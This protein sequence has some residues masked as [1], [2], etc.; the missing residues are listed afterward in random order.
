[1]VCLSHALA[2]K[3]SVIL[4]EKILLDQLAQGDRDAFWQ[5]WELHRDYLYHRCRFW[6]GGNYSEGEEALSLA[7]LKAWE[8]LP[9]YAAQITNVKAWLTRMTHNLCV[10]L[11][12][13]R[14]RTAIGVDKIEEITS[15]E[16]ES[17]ASNNY[18]PEANLLRRELEM[19]IRQQINALPPR[20]RSP[21]VLRF[22]QDMSYQAIAQK[23]QISRDNVYKRIQQA[24]EFLQKQLQRYF[25]GL[26][27]S[28][29][30]QN[31]EKAFVDHNSSHEE[32][33]SEAIAKGF[34]SSEIASTLAEFSNQQ[35]NYQVTALC[36]ELLSV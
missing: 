2:H 25:S 17:L 23:L 29:D 35:I 24:R 27:D 31:T 15:S 13:K 10:D 26:A 19:M 9:N 22:Y 28:V 36:L 6:M 32:L 8:K 33:T 3:S 11:H 5:L 12:R 21:F 18:S 1:M 14:Q 20:L 30:Q 34:D 7:M 16:Q 4:D